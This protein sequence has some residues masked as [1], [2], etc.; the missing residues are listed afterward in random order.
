MGTTSCVVILKENKVWYGHIGDS[1]IYYYCAEHHALFHLTRDHSVVQ[2][3]VDRGVISPEEAEHHPEKNKIYKTLGHVR[4]IE[5]DI[6]DTPLLPADDDMILICSDGLSGMISDKEI[7]ET[8]EKYKNDVPVA[9]QTL[10]ERAKASG[11]LDNITAQ[12]VKFADTPYRHSTF[13][14]ISEGVSCSTPNPRKKSKKKYIA[15]WA[16]MIICTLIA[17]ILLALPSLSPRHTATDAASAVQPAVPD[18]PKATAA[19]EKEVEGMTNIG[20][21]PQGYNIF[22]AGEIAG[23]E[24]FRGLV[25]R[26]DGSYYKADFQYDPSDSSTPFKQI[27]PDKVE[28]YDSQGHKIN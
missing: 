22:A 5:P 12:L 2:T 7:L 24:Q 13:A 6:I 10:V 3:L 19:W 14:P 17:A 20:T 11:G 4:D 23:K 15:L 8:L 16:G 27:N 28:R 25:V 9:A 1:R 21:T 18:H 26:S